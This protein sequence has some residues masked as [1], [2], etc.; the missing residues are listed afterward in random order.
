[1][2][3]QLANCLVALGGDA[4][5]TVPKYGITA[6]EIAVLRAIHGDD[7]VLDVEPVGSVERSHK[8]ERGRLAD[9][10]ARVVNG[11]R[12][13]PEV[14]A[15]FPG[16]AARVFET[17]DE[18]E[19]DASFFKATARM[20]AK[21]AK[22]AEPEPVPEPEAEKPKRTRK[23]KPVEV[24]PAPEPE[25]DDEDDGIGDMPNASGVMD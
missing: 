8:A 16:A 25:E 13:S 14:D 22:V 7:A 18:L 10:Y 21:P 5:N 15:L 1:M 2:P 19:L 11:A 4:G 17:I 23:V 20:T 12:R 3:L 6:A 24:K 9:I